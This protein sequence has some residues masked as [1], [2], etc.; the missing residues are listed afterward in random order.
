MNSRNPLVSILIPCHNAETWLG[1]TIKS[2][3]SQT[4]NNKEIILVDDGST[5]NSLQIAK[6]FESSSVRIISQENKGASAARNTAL[7]NAQGDFIQYLDADDL[8]AADKITQQINFLQQSDSNHNYLVAASWGRFYTSTTET[9][10]VPEPVWQDMSPVNWLICSWTGGGMMHPA[11]WLIPRKLSEKAGIWNE[12]L[13][14]NDDGE[15]FCRVILASDGII[16]CREAKSYYRSGLPN[17]LSR[18][19]SSSGLISALKSIELCTESLLA[20]NNNKCTRNACADAFQRFVYSTYPDE[21]DLISEAERK[22]ERL[23]G[24]TLEPSGGKLFQMFSKFVGWKAAKKLQ[25]LSYS[26]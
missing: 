8:L 11:A 26:L 4:W 12:E 7:K 21:I 9:K 10:F 17:S 25:R 16:F 24:S 18:T 19:K 1:E 22:V 20:V 23:G 14:L 15:Y 5:D 2:A 3:L 6:S 13:S